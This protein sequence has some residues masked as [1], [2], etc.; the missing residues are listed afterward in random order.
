[1]KNFSLPSVYDGILGLTKTD[2]VN[3]VFNNLPNLTRSVDHINNAF[4]DTFFQKLL[5]GKFLITDL[6]NNTNELK[7]DLFKS[8][9]SKDLIDDLLNGSFDLTDLYNTFND[10]INFEPFCRNHFLNHILTVDNSTDANILIQALCQLNIRN[11]TMDLN[12]FVNDLNYDMINRYVSLKNY[13]QKNNWPFL[14]QF[15]NLSQLFNEKEIQNDIEKLKDL[16]KTVKQLSS[17]AELLNNLPNLTEI[18]RII[19]RL[20]QIIELVQN[21]RDLIQL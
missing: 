8:G 1:M 10:T 5:D 13:K 7:N 15:G 6:F 9:M 12:V 19:P 14:L 17:Y 11:F 4:N 16:E 20:I 3:T 21:Q 18:A 2:G